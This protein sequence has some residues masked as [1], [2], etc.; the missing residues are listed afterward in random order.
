MNYGFNYSHTISGDNMV[1]DID[2][3]EEYEQ[4]DNLSLFFETVAWEGLTYRFESMNTLDTDRC[5]IR[6]RYT[7]GTIATGT[8][9][10]IEDSCSKTG[11]KLAI[12]IRGT[13]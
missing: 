7:G 9:N 6:S 3:I 4:G 12:K 2:K 5:R 13:F 1:W 8:L 11:V 10:E